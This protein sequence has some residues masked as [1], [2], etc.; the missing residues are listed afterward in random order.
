MVDTLG[1]RF[2]IMSFSVLVLV[3]QVIT[4][5]GCSVHS[6][7]TML[8]GERAPLYAPARGGPWLGGQASGVTD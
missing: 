8:L 3:G 6:M 4:A 5:L 1:M 2:S 7:A